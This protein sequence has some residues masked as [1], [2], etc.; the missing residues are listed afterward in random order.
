MSIPDIYL[1]P[2]HCQIGHV[3]KRSRK[4]DSQPLEPPNN[5]R[6]E[7]QRIGMSMAELAD[8]AGTTAPTINKLEKSQRQL[9]LGWIYRIA[10]GL[11]VRPSSL[12]K[13]IDQTQSLT[14]IPVRVCGTVQAGIFQEALEWPPEDQYDVWVPVRPEYSGLPHF[15]VRVSGPSMDR[16]FPD[17]TIVVCVRLRDMVGYLPESGRRYLIYRRDEKGGVE[18]TIKELRVDDGGFAWLWPRSSHPDYQQPWRLDSLSNHLPD[19]DEDLVIWA[20]VI[21]AYNP[22]D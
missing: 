16:K 22:E 2:G 10:E 3:Q 18:A 17:G 9:T 5:I 12:I 11:G 6:E 7:R 4:K 19:G 1:G 13:D 20:L 14:T 21:G 8:R 15:A